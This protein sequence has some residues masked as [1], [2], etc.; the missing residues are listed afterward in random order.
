MYSSKDFFISALG[1]S[2]P[3]YYHNYDIMV[4]RASEPIPFCIIKTQNDG[5][6]V[7]RVNSWNNEDA[8]EGI[9]VMV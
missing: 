4:Q 5:S 1:I 6:T 9:I 7:L 2:V 3:M 8:E